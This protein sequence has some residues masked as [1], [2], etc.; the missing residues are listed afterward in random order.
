M[1]KMVRQRN[2][3]VRVTNKG[4]AVAL[5][6]PGRGEIVIQSDHLRGA[7]TEA[8]P[9]TESVVLEHGRGSKLPTVTVRFQ[10]AP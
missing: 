1:M 9:F 7:D 4:V 2:G 8:G 5:I 10:E 6:K 3:M